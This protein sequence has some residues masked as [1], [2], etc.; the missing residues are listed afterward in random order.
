MNTQQGGN[1]LQG[2]ERIIWML[3]ILKELKAVGAAG[4]EA[5]GGKVA[6]H[7]DQFIRSHHPYR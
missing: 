4:P 1:L 3:M 2:N 7:A 5:A 6:D